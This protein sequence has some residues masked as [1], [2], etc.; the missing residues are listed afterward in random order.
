MENLEICY[1]SQKA[2][3]SNWKFRLCSKCLRAQSEILSPTIG[4]S[5]WIPERSSPVSQHARWSWS[6]A[7][8]PPHPIACIFSCLNSRNWSSLTMT[9]VDPVALAHNLFHCLPA[10]WWTVCAAAAQLLAGKLLLGWE[11]RGE[12]GF[13]GCLWLWAVFCAGLSQD[14]IVLTAQLCCP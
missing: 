11:A 14:L 9:V 8:I 3:L 10:K 5:V 4:R 13:W 7:P 12:W 6:S 1:S 2:C